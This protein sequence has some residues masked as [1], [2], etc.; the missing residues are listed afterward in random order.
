MSFTITIIIATI[1]VAMLG[2]VGAVGECVWG[3]DAVLEVRQ[4]TEEEEEGVP[5]EDVTCGGVLKK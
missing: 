4:L 3:G 1:A 2:G 5:G